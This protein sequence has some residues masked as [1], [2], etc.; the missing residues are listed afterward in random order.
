MKSRSTMGLLRYCFALRF[1]LTCSS[2]PSYVYGNVSNPVLRS[3][4]EIPLAPTRPLPEKVIVGYTHDCDEK[5]KK[6][7]RQGVNVIIWSF[8]ELKPYGNLAELDFRCIRD[9]IFEMDSEGYDDTVHSVSFGGWN[10]PQFDPS[11][12]TA[13]EWFMAWKKEVG[14]VFHGLDFDFEGN[15]DLSSQRN[16]FS[17]QALDMMGNVS[18]LAKQ[19]G[20]I[21]S[22]APPQSYLDI[23]STK[24]SQYVN[25]TDSAR[26]WHSEF[27]YFG[28]NVYAYVL[29][30][31]GDHIDLI[32]VQFYESYSRAAMEIIFN[33]LAP[34]AYLSQYVQDLKNKNQQFFVDFESASSLDLNS[35]NVALPLSKLVWGFANQW[36]NSTEDKHVYFPPESI[37]A[38]YQDLVDWM[39]E[40]KGFMFWC[41]ANEGTNGVYYAKE[42]NDILHIRSGEF[43]EE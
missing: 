12:E 31:Y 38:A 5:T 4:P 8:M 18:R 9:L 19:D 22:I 34:E 42:L 20:Y 24:F 29:A 28:E 37:Q 2:L 27:Q 35:Q 3:V 10:G 1:V 36:V 25:L 13:E 15:D 41:I 14:N 33:K 30:K 17:K 43:S 39:M 7:I 26:S 21:V 32:L 40:P 23:H 16:Y 6:A 11:F